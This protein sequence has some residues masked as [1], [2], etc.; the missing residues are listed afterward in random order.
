VRLS[1]VGS[2]RGM[3]GQVERELRIAST[4]VS[5]PPMAG[6]AL[7]KERKLQIA[8]CSSPQKGY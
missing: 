4:A 3:P 5:E 1:P 6:A 7:P 2:I 8:T